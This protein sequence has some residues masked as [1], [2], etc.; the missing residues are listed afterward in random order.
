MLTPAEQHF[1]NSQELTVM[2]QKMEILVIN[3][4]EKQITQTE[5]ENEFY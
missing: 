1:K 5:E 3:D 4:N 2:K